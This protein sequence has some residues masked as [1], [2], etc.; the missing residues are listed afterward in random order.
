MTVV[1]FCAVIQIEFN[2]S[3]RELPQRSHQRNLETHPLRN[4][5]PHHLLW[6]LWTT[7]RR[8]RELV[9]NITHFFQDMFRN[10]EAQAGE[11]S[12]EK[13]P[14]LTEMAVGGSFMALTIAV[15]LVVLFKR[16]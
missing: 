14:S 7:R 3:P 1:I 8:L 5:L 11:A 12:S 6:T 4:N 10:V 16:A 9:N 13:G 2:L 15:I